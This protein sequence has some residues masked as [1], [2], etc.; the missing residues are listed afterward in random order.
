MKVFGSSCLVLLALI[1]AT[2]GAPYE[3]GNPGI[4]WTEEQADIVKNKLL[5][6]WKSS[7]NIIND[8]DFKNPQAPASHTDYVYDPDRRLSTVDCDL[9]E[10]LCETYWGDKRRSNMA[11]TEP[12]AI[13]LA[14]HDC[15]PYTD[16]TGG[17]DGC[18]NFQENI[19]DNNMLQPTIA[20]LVSVFD[21]SNNPIYESHFRRRCTSKKIFLLVLINWNRLQRN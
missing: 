6:L 19:E 15:K 4:N 16:G 17:C 13:R 2:T 3:A 9:N 8:F 12:K 20:I 11:F 21:S 10:S 14:F 5:K 18:L 1:K 7:Y